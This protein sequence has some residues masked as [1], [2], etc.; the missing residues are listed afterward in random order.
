[1][2]PVVDEFVGVFGWVVTDSQPGRDGMQRLRQFIRER[3]GDKDADCL[4]RGQGSFAPV[5][6]F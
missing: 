1:M 4:V 2:W 3:M 5:R 6:P